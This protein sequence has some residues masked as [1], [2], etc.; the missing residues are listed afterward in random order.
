[1]K[2]NDFDGHTGLQPRIVD[3]V[4]RSANVDLQQR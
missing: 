2:E 4:C 3:V 1:M